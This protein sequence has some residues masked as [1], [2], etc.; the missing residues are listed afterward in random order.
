MPTREREHLLLAIDLSNTGIKLGLYPR[1]S[2]ELL[3]R[4]RIATEREKTADEYAMLLAELCVTPACAWKISRRDH[5]ERHAVA[6]SRLSGA[7]PRYLD[8]GAIV[9]THST[10]LAFA[11]WWTTPGRPGR[12]AC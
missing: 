11:C 12:T 9:M 3:A 2:G 7:D 4:W 5:G 10:T 8:R 6:Y 1:G